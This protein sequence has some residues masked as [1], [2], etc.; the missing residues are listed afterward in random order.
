[1]A[2]YGRDLAYI[3]DTGFS[4]FVQRA[5]PGLLKILRLRGVTRG[6]IVDLGSGSGVWAE[7]LVKAGYDVLGIE[8]SPFMVAIARKRVPDARFHVGSFLNTT[9]P[10]CRT[11]TSIGECLCYLLDRGNNR[12]QLGRLFHRVYEALHPGGVFVFD[13]AVPGR[14]GPSGSRTSFRVESDWAVLTEVEEDRRRCLLT[15]RITT[16]RKLGLLYGRSEEVHLQ[17]LFKVREITRLLQKAGFRTQ[18]MRSYG[19]F[20][21]PHGNVAVVACREPEQES[22]K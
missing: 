20:R 9:L 14:G 16:F 8:L 21:L 12:R 22:R 5:A 19:R 7:I 10:A 3:H 1:M 18:V 4:G 11:V 17:R 15:R 2:G 13:F 6:L